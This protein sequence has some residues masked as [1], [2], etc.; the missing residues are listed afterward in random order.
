LCEKEKKRGVKK[1]VEN[2]KKSIG[3]KLAYKEKA[4]KLEN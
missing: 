3:K 2:K 4:K 1:K